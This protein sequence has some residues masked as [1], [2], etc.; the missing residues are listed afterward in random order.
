MSLMF[1][2]PC[3]FWVCTSLHISEFTGSRSFKGFRSILRHSIHEPALEA[4]LGGNTVGSPP[5][6]YMLGANRSASFASLA[7]ATTRT[8]LES[9]HVCT[10]YL[11]AVWCRPDPT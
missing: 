9:V 7:A 10:E 6:I 8:P 1:E 5:L 4:R 11:P 2:N 3:V